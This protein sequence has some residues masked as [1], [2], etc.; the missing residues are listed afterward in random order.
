M[1]VV[2]DAAAEAATTVFKRHPPKVVHINNKQRKLQRQAS[3]EAFEGDDN[4]AFSSC[5]HHGY[6]ISRHKTKVVPTSIKMKLRIVAIPC[7]VWEKRSIRSLS[8]EEFKLFLK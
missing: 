6:Y 8:F 1:L 2:A 4:H 5:I 3:N 7:Y